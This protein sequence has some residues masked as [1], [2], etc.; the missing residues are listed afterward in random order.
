MLKLIAGFAALVPFLLTAVALAQP[1]TA[2][3]ITAEPSPTSPPVSPTATS[4]PVPSPF[5]VGDLA[6]ELRGEIL[7][8]DGMPIPPPEREHQVVLTWTGPDDV[9]GSYAVYRLDGGP[10]GTPLLI[11]TL[12]ALTGRNQYSEPIHWTLPLT[13]YQVRSVVGSEFGPAAQVCTPRPPGPDGPGP[14]AT[15]SPTP[16]PPPT[17]SGLPDDSAASGS[18]PLTYL[19]LAGVVAVGTWLAYGWHRRQL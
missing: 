17:G 3:P 19:V 4:T 18:A 13:C 2:T 7:E 12:P 11:S 6:V 8:P 5:P 1:S 10:S 16:I 14:G 15:L 9:V